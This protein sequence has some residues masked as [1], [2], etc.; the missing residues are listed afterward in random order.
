MTA[1]QLEELKE[2]HAGICNLIVVEFCEKH[3]FEFDFWVDV[4]HIFLASD[5]FIDFID[6]KYDLFSEQPEG[7]FLNY[8]DD[9]IQFPDVSL[10]YQS[11]C[12]GLRHENLSDEKKQK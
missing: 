1:D 7:Q 12:K 11:Y 4:G 5:F 2:L 10:N 6:A 8:Y 9:C 3:D